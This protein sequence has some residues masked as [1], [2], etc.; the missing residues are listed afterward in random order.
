MSLRHNCVGERTALARKTFTDDYRYTRATSETPEPEFY[1]RFYVLSKLDTRTRSFG[2]VYQRE[3]SGNLG[4][5]VK[6]W[7]SG[8]NYHE[9]WRCAKKKKCGK[10]AGGGAKKR[11]PG[12]LTSAR[13]RPG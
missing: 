11:P 4:Y 6:G 5:V 1:R 13:A 9:N 3:M 10:A 2:R 7:L 8:V 12:R